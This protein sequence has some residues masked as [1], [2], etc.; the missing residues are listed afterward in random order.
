LAYNKLAT[1]DN[2]NRKGCKKDTHC[3]Y[4]GEN[5]SI[6]HLFF[7]C[8]VAKVIWSYIS[9]LVGIEVGGDYVSVASKWLSKE[10]NYCINVIS[11]AALRSIW[12]TRNA[13]IFDKQVWSSVKWILRKIRILLLDWEVMCKKSKMG[14]MK[15]WLSGLERLIQEP[16]R[17][18]NA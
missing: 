3:C 7:E 17:I 13:M 5:E 14:E 2:L 1:V 4:C 10:K 12:L 6:S 16:L 11:A 18:G 15:A 9:D 8:V